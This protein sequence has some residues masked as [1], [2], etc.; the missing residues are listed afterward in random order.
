MSRILANQ[1]G[2]LVNTNKNKNKNVV[3]ENILGT[4]IFGKYALGSSVFG[5]GEGVRGS[6]GND[7]SSG[8]DGDG[9]GS[10]GTTFLPFSR[11]RPDIASYFARFGRPP[12]FSGA[13]QQQ[14]VSTGVALAY[15]CGPAGLVREASR[16]AGDAGMDFHSETFEL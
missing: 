7:N 12:I 2:S 1:A 15:A 16:V 4:E 9:S 14:H 3:G 6:G 11:G 10:D 5:R 8:S 13:H